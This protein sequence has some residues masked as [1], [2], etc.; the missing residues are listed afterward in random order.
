VEVPPDRSGGY[1]LYGIVIYMKQETQSQNE[2]PVGI[3]ISRGWE[4]ATTPRFSAYEWGPGPEDEIEQ[5][6]VAT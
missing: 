5:D 6:A 4:P 3:V 1:L 2:E